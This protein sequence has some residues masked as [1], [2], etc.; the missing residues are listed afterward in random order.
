ML[1]VLVGREEDMLLDGFGAI[2]LI[3]S[4]VCLVGFDLAALRGCHTLNVR[5]LSCF[6]NSQI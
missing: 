1:L 4:M 5:L 6:K 2:Y 3:Q